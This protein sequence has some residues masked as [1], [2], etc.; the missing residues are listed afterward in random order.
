MPLAQRYPSLRR[1]LRG[2]ARALPYL[3][4]SVIAGVQPV[5][6]D[7]AP[8]PFEALADFVTA[9]PE[10]RGPTLPFPDSVARPTLAGVD[11]CAEL[12]PVCVHA[13]PDVP[14]ARVQRALAAADAAYAWL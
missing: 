4:V 10:Y 13:A 14:D 2:A 12:T 9:P 11:A 8:S 6:A 1:G 7:E 3:C 5:H